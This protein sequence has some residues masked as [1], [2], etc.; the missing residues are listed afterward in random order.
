LISFSN[1]Y[2][3]CSF[4]SLEFHKDSDRLNSRKDRLEISDLRE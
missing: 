1:G 2:D 4:N 3:E